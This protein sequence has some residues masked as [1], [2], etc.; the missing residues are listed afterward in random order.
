[1]FL[2][3]GIPVET[4]FVVGLEI[5]PSNSNVSRPLYTSRNRFRGGFGDKVLKLKCF[6]RFLLKPILKRLAGKQFFKKAC[7]T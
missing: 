2:V 5:R 1:M 4:A 6:L 7:E 3:L